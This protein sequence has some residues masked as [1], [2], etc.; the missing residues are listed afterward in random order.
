VLYDWANSGFG[1]IVIGPVFQVFFT[2]VLMPEQAGWMGAEVEGVPRGLEVMGVRAWGSGV[3]AGLVSL[4]ALLICI[5]APVLGALADRRGLQKPL[6]VGFASAGAAVTLLA[7]TLAEGDWLLGAAIYVAGYVCFGV[8]NAFYNSYLTVIAPTAVHGRLSGYGF[9]AGYI[10]GLVAMLAAVYFLPTN[11]GLAAAGVWWFVFSLPAFWLLPNPPGTAGAER[12][13]VFGP[14]RQVWRTFRE[15]RKY[16]V[17]FLFLL[18]FLLYN[19]GVET[20]ISLS[21]AFG[22]DVLDMNEEQLVL[23]FS[24]VQGVAFGGAILCGHLA[25]RVGNKP[26]ILGNLFVWIA[27]ATLTL[28]I[29]EPWQFIAIGCGIGLVLGGVQSS[30]RAL[31]AKLAP[32]AIRNE[33]F[34]FYAVGSKAVA[35]LGPLLYLLLTLVAGP[36][37]GAVAVLPFLIVGAWLLWRVKVEE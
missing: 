8:S 22:S 7:A 35:T 14:F 34:G 26:V 15:I 23:M 37:W 29:T 33:A 21:G 2:S 19:N 12:L 11:W 4:A 9:A 27:G 36:R 5:L 20:V 10:G 31:M 32:P 30:S 13:D 3:L 25:D 16:R 17:L 28:F 6:F 1:L 24:L 18:A